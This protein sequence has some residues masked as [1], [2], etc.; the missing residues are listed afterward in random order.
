VAVDD[1]FSGNDQDPGLPNPLPGLRLWLSLTTFLVAAGPFCCTG[2]FGAFLALWVWTRAGDALARADAGLHPPA[3][4]KEAKTLRRVAFGLMSTSALS[5]C[6]QSF[7]WG[8]GVYEW[9]AVAILNAV[10]AAVELPAAP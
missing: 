10:G 4:G 2:G 6:L 8:Q 7:L 1:L 3:I 9:V 5:L